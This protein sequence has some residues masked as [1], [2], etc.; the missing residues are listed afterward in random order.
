MVEARTEVKKRKERKEWR[1]SNLGY[2]QKEEGRKEGEERREGDIKRAGLILPN[3]S[4]AYMMAFPTGNTTLQVIPDGCLGVFCFWCLDL[5]IREDL[6]AWSIVHRVYILI[7]LCIYP[8][9]P[10]LLCSPSPLSSLPELHFLSTVSFRLILQPE[11]D[12][13]S[14]RDGLG[15]AHS[16]QAYIVTSA[17]L[18]SDFA[19]WFYF[20]GLSGQRNIINI[21]YLF[22][23]YTVYILNILYT[24]YIIY[25]LYIYI[26]CTE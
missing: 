4:N 13:L 26:L 1:G 11:M 8:F 23:L 3:F 16:P 21:A 25:I 10:S 24:L 5:C 22:S 18:C 19:R 17:G 14:H 12:P 9:T 2:G 7:L 6:L 15:L 20:G